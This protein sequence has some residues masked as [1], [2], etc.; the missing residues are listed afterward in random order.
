MIKKVIKK[1]IKSLQLKNRYVHLFK[2]YLK[3]LNNNLK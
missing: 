2:Y 1:L 3:R